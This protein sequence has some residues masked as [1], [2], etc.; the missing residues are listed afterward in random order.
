MLGKRQQGPGARGEGKRW[1]FYRHG[2]SVKKIS[3]FRTGKI[4][5]GNRNAKPGKIFPELEVESGKKI[6]GLGSFGNTVPFWLF[7]EISFHF[8]I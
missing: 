1:A 8:W 7:F 6:S 3:S 4:Y 2:E 5:S